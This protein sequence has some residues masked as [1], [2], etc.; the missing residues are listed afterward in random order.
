MK[1]P[2]RKFGPQRVKSNCPF[3]ENFHISSVTIVNYYRKLFDARAIRHYQIEEAKEALDGR[4]FRPAW[5]SRSL[6]EREKQSGG[7]FSQQTDLIDFQV[8][9]RRL[10]P[11]TCVRGTR[12][13]EADFHSRSSALGQEINAQ[14]RGR[15]ALNLMRAAGKRLIASLS[16]KHERTFVPGFTKPDLCQR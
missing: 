7:R 4:S 1:P 2:W 5:R 15:K 10:N 14:P 6:H 16:A 12:P 9:A 11:R 13:E 8:R 3:V